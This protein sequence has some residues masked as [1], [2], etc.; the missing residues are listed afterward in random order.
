[1]ISI[2]SLRLT[3]VSGAML[4]NWIAQIAP[5]RLRKLWLSYPTVSAADIARIRTVLPT[6]DLNS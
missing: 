4:V 3:G 5:G 6:C 2:V 1:V